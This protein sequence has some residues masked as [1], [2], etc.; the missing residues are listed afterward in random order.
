MKAFSGGDPRPLHGI[1]ASS[2]AEPVLE[3]DLQSHRHQTHLMATRDLSQYSIV[4]STTKRRTRSKGGI[5]TRK[6]SRVTANLR[7]L[8]PIVKCVRIPHPVGDR[9]HSTLILV[10][11]IHAMPPSMA[12]RQA[13]THPSRDIQRRN[14]SRN[15]EIRARQGTEIT[16]VAHAHTHAHGSLA[17]NASMTPPYAT[18]W[19]A[20]KGRSHGL[21]IGKL[22]LQKMLLLLL[23]SLD[24]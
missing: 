16:E 4:S 13:A 21:V 20:G 24:L 23:K 12:T 5:R 1:A 7:S 17:L 19:L 10:D 9:T 14:G 22:L 11:D 18:R 3:Q 2:A 15:T 8:E 6:L